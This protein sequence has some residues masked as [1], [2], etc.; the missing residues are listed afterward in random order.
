[1]VILIF[2][3]YFDYVP[4]IILGPMDFTKYTVKLGALL[5]A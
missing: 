3:F 4:N 1:M 2:D 5:P